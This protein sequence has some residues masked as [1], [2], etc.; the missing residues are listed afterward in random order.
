MIS[1]TADNSVPAAGARLCALAKSMSQLKNE[2]DLWNLMTEHLRQEY[3]IDTAM[4]AFAHSIHA[5]S[6][7]DP[8]QQF[9]I[10]HNV[11]PD[12]LTAHDGL[13]LKDD[14]IFP[15]VIRGSPKILWYEVESKSLAPNQL[16]RL[17][18]DERLGYGAGLS[19]GGRFGSGVGAYCMCMGARHQSESDFYNFIRTR[20]DEIENAVQQ[21]EIHMRPAMVARRIR[22]TPKQRHVL[23]LSIAGHTAKSIARRLGMSPRSIE[24][25]LVRAR[26]SLNAESTVEAVAK[27]IIFE[28]MG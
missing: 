11:P 15:Q 7:S 3:G 20:V 26:K 14:C 9:F 21:F 19:V 28:M 8:Y 1:V 17:A 6:Q 2:D 22:L 23:E 5:K 27:A 12:S 25:L 24:H 16:R 10:K 18:L 4:F 13:N